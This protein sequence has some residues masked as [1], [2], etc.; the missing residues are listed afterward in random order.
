MKVL[1]TSIFS[2]LSLTVFAQAEIAAVSSIQ[3]QATIRMAKSTKRCKYFSAS[4]PVTMADGTVKSIADVRVGEHVKTCKDG[5][6]ATTQVRQIDVFNQPTSLLTAVYLRPVVDEA[7]ADS[8][9]VPALLLEATPHHKVQT[10]R[11]R[12]RMKRL[13][14][15][16]IL[17]HYEPSTGI[18]SSWKVGAVQQNARR[19]SKAY[20][21][22]TVDGT[23]LVDNVMVANN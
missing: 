17:Y 12:K 13:S 18:V 11:G 7:S 6:T 22:E 10:N 9:M 8:P 15:N 1:T 5:K 20:N 16:D 21:I 14:K 4:A 2:L 23:Y 19:V 3:S